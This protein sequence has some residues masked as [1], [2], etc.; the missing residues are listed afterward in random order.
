M[1]KHKNLFVDASVCT[2]ANCIVTLLALVSSFLV[3]RDLGPYLVGVIAT[4]NLSTYY[5]T[6]S[7]LGILM[8]AERELP[9]CWGAGE[10]ERFERIR[11]STFTIVLITAA[12]CSLGIVIWA[13][14]SRSNLNASIFWGALVY[15]IVV[16]GQQ[17]VFF[18]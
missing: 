10:T 17:C 8:A 11:Y 3:R 18:Y 12:L 13:V 6:F 15:A 5:S 4:L 16:S 2:F 14:L 7:N 9:Y 1:M